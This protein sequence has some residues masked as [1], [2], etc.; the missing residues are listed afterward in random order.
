VLG[1]RGG[2]TVDRLPDGSGQVMS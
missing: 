1:R 2:R